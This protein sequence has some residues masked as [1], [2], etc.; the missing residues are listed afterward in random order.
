MSI[1]NHDFSKGQLDQNVHIDQRV[2]PFQLKVWD[3]KNT[4]YI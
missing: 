2:R 4:C 3:M 1:I